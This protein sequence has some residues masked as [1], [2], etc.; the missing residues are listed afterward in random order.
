[1]PFSEH[2]EKALL[3]RAVGRSPEAKRWVAFLTAEPTKTE[4]GTSIEAKEAKYK[5]HGRVETEGVAW[6]KAATGSAPCKISNEK[7]IP[8]KKFEAG[9]EEESSKVTW[10]SICDA[11]TAGNQVALG[12]LTSEVV[13]AAGNPEAE[14]AVGALEL[15]LT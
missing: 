9:G 6:W 15:T 10:V 5:G 8:A 2:E 3:E 14:F 13:I 1:M 12:K 7:L 11:A 4:S